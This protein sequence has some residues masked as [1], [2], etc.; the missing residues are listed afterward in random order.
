MSGGD[1]PGSPVVRTQCASAG[2]RE[3]IPGPRT[4]P[5]E[6]AKKKKKNTENQQGKKI[7]SPNTQ[8]SSEVLARPHKLSSVSWVNVPSTRNV[9]SDVYRETAV[10]HI[11]IS[12]II[13]T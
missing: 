8:D 2:A 3:Q 13:F 5:C 10:L 1:R 6:T 9:A 12:F 11:L 4:K 7:N